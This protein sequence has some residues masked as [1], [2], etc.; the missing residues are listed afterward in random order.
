MSKKTEQESV[1]EPFEPEDTDWVSLR[2]H[3]KPFMELKTPMGL[4]LTACG[5][6]ATPAE[7]KATGCTVRSYFNIKGSLPEH[8][9]TQLPKL[10]ALANSKGW[11]DCVDPSNPSGCFDF[12]HED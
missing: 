2:E 10:C 12:E 3:A 4:F 7:E 11:L 6:K 1:V 5:T 9:R 8:V